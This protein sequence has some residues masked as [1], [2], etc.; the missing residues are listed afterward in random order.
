[1]KVPEES[2][3]RRLES[4]PVARLASVDEAGRPH[5]VPIVFAKVG[6]RLYSPVDGKPKADRELA[7]VRYLRARSA[8]SLLLDEY[9]GD[10]TR[11]WWIRI[12]VVARVIHPADPE[13]DPEVG[14]AVAALRRKYPQYEGVLVL[15]EPA[16]LLA[17]DVGRIQSWCA[18]HS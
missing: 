7:R 18:A 16:T 4:W 6:A 8:A 5:Q 15:G 9:D 1:M 14:R 2:I 12:D 17:F 13:R 11:L 3:Q 10:W